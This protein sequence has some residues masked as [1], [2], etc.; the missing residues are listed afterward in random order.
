MEILAFQPGHLLDLVVEPSLLLTVFDYLDLRSISRLESS[1]SQLREMVVQTSIYKRRWKE[2]KQRTD[3]GS[4]DTGRRM[5]V[6]TE[7]DS[8]MESSRHFKKKLS[9]YYLRN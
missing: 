1:S 5:K 8:K 2:I 7:W 3:E 6:D 4:A 9:E